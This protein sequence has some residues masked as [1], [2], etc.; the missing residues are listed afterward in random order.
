MPALPPIVSDFLTRIKNDLSVGSDLATPGSGNIRGAAQNYLRAQDMA[1]ALELLQDVLSN[2]AATGVV[3][4]TGLPSADDTLV[5]GDITYTWKAAPSAAFEVDIGADADGCVTNLVAAI[6]LTG[7]AGVTYG[8]DTT[9]H[10]EV[11]AADGAGSTVDLTAFDVGAVG[12]SIV[13]TESMANTTIS[14]SGTLTG[15]S[16]GITLTATGNGTVS[17]FV[18]GASTFTA[19]AHIGDTFTFDAAT[20]TA[21]LQGVVATVVSNTTTTLTFAENLPAATAT[22]DDGI[23]TS[24]SMSGAIAE[25]RQGAGPADAPRGNVY[26]HSRTVADALNRLTTQLGATQTERN[27]GRPG[28]KVATGS[29]TSVVELE[30]AGIPFRIDEL[31]GAKIVVAGQDPRIVVQSDETSVTV[32]KA[33]ASAPAATTAVTLTV[34]ADQAHKTYGKLTVHPGAQPGENHVLADQIG[35]AEA[36]VVAFTLPA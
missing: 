4:F 7:T 8:A 10:P 16:D 5:V 30:T 3:T 1:S 25:L 20:T 34:A 33:Y 6:N 24:T 31:R 35:Q 17:T 21:D 32:N 36:A 15:G 2:P 14:G 23:L 26:G 29:S 28:L 22:G 9:I 11:F 27:L 13:F 12:N 19:N 18:E